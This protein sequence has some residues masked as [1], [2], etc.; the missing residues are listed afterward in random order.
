MPTT[1]TQKE[2]TIRTWNFV[3]RCLDPVKVTSTKFL[4]QILKKNFKILKKIFKILKK[5]FKILKKII[6]I[7]KENYQNFET[8]L[9]HCGSKGIRALDFKVVYDVGTNYTL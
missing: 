6:K 9:I 2:P 1:P 5:I 8:I 4:L 7:L 3:A